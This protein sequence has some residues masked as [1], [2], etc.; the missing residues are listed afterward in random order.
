[1]I[2]S[3]NRSSLNMKILIREII[4]FITLIVIFSLRVC[5]AVD[6]GGP[7]IS[8]TIVVDNSGKSSNFTSFQAAIDS[9][10]SSNSKWVKIQI[11]AGTYKYVILLC[12]CMV[13]L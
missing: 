7:Q 5:R 1:V 6:C 2:V 13:T 9:I 4:L 8:S 3:T 10:P 11:N 12:F